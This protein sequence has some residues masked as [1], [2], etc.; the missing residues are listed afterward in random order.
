MDPQQRMLGQRLLSRPPPHTEHQA[1][2]VPWRVV[3]VTESARP[4]GS[5][6]CRLSFSFTLYFQFLNTFILTCKS[7][8]VCCGN[9]HGNNCLCHFLFEGLHCAEGY[10]TLQL[11]RWA[12]RKRVEGWQLF[13]NQFFS[14]SEL[15]LKAFLYMLPITIFSASVSS[16]FQ[17]KS[18]HILC[19]RE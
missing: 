4:A 19:C 8:H 16:F 13:Q 14:N 2:H 11:L 15:L 18:D 17:F 7:D 10:Q 1:P 3:T 5:G 12:S 9:T 6:Q